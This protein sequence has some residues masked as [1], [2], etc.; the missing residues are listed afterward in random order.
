MSS[1]RQ[2]FVLSLYL[3]AGLG[4][5]MLALAETGVPLGS[6][7]T[8]ARL[9]AIASIFPALLTLPI[10]A[11]A[12]QVVEK[13]GWSIGPRV[14][15]GLGLVALMVALLE[16]W[17]RNIEGRLLFGAHLLVYLTWILLWQEK[18]GRQR[19]GLVALA[20]LQVAVGSVLTTAGW[21]GASLVL[22]LGLSIWT[23]VLLQISAAEDR[24]SAASDLARESL[25][26]G[27][28]S[29]LAPGRVSPLGHATVSHW[30]KRPVLGTVLLTLAGSLSIGAMFFL[31]V[32]RIDFGLTAFHETEEPLGRRRITGFTDRVRLGAFGQLLESSAPA[33]DVRIFNEAGESLDVE[34]YAARQGMDEPLFRGLTLA[35]YEDGEWFAERGDI[36]TGLRPEPFTEAVRQ[37]YH[38]RMDDSPVLFA[39]APVIAGRIEDSDQMI[40]HYLDTQVLRGRDVGD[41]GTRYE[42]YSPTQPDAEASERYRRRV[43]NHDIEDYLSLPGDLDRLAAT[44]QLVVGETATT[45][46]EKAERLLTYLRDSGE[47]RYSLSGDVIDPRLDPIEDFLLNRKSGHCE[48][49]ASALALM[50]RAEGVPSRVVN[51]YKGGETNGVIGRYEVQQRHAH[52]WVEAYID[53]RWITLDPSP[54][55]EREAVVAEN[56]AQLPLWNAL[57]TSSSTVWRDYVVQLNMARQREAL[58]PLRDTAVLVYDTARNEWWPSFKAH[59][60]QFAT[61]P[62]RWFSWQGGLVTF[63]GLLMAVGCWWLTRRLARRFQRGGRH[64][65]R[66][67]DRKMMIDFYEDFRRLCRER[68]WRAEPTQTPREFAARVTDSLDA[69]RLSPELLTLPAELTT[70][71]YQL[72][73]GELELRDGR[74]ELLRDRLAALRT[75]LAHADDGEKHSPNGSGD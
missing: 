21:Y 2:V 60:Y 33:F 48:F 45:D 54:S 16:L 14:A 34:Q 11:A 41:R 28:A 26:L 39:I 50:L 23:L 70:D 3:L 64:D 38:L 61:D 71:Y 75:S 44:A 66:A 24:H 62:S 6:L 7:L 68:G 35:R 20:I 42:V 73:F 46:R 30:P 74:R 1:I 15:S 27:T 67:R 32:P 5:T 52:S 36:G 31:L 19:W 37:E 49:F 17:F 25:P 69:M 40:R 29:L 13:R 43:R 53:D 9:G 65:A 55:S 59:V 18:S 57:L 8:M 47:F 72:R 56:A 51:G 10:A 22:F 4:A 12:Y 63:V 58:S